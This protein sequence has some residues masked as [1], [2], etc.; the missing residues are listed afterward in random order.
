[1]ARTRDG[2]QQSGWRRVR[3]TL[4]F[5]SAAIVVLA[6]CGGSSKPTASASSSAAPTTT[7]VP[8][9]TAAPVIAA[10]GLTGTVSV[11]AG[12][13]R[14]D[15][16]GVPGPASDASLGDKVHYTVAPNGD[17][18]LTNGT[19]D[20]LKISGGQVIKYAQLDADASG[21]G[22]VAIAPD[23][24]LFVATPSKVVKITTDGTSVVVLSTAASGLSSSLGPIAV[25]TAG[26]L[27]VADGLRRITRVAPDGTTA[28]VAG[29]GVQ[30][31][32]DSTVGDGGPAIAAPLGVP[33]QLVV[34]ADE[35]LFIADS[36]T[37]SVRRVSSTG[38]ITT[39][40]G[41]G[42]TSLSAGGTYAPD[43]TKPTDLKLAEVVGIAIDGKGRIYVA[44]GLNHAIF[45]F[46][47]GGGIELVIGDQKGGGQTPG[48]AA[49]ATRAT[50]VGELAV[51]AQGNLVFLDARVIK[52]IAG[53]GS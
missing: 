48:L 3:R 7:S 12:N 34:D 47:P 5:A 14:D 50:N 17:I 33:T 20:V 15:G 37:H 18:F 11:V 19:V 38:T 27:Y 22:G 35:N 40:A 8:S 36:S 44:D 43:G 2:H 41:G 39:I 6:G 49:D 30:A 42:T 29:T 4:L 45:R 26:N 13:G 10:R 21:T 23:G 46:S 24:S 52:R 28:V 1:M 51:D 9:T 31:K 32:P 53:A 25:D 16:K